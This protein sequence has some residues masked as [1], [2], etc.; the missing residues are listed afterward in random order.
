MPKRKKLPPIPDYEVIGSHSEKSYIQKARPLQSLSATNLTLPELKILDAYLARI[1]SHN[2]DARYVRFDKGELER[3]LGVTQL[4]K[5]DLS[6]RIDNLF[7]VI[8]ITDEHKPTKFSKIALFS[9]AECEQDENGQWQ[10]D[11]ACSV[12]AMEYMFNIDNIGYL[13]YRLKNVINLT[14]RYSYILFLYLVDNRFRKTWKIDL[15]D[16]KKLMNCTAE[17]YTE[18]KFF[19]SEI[20]KKCQNEIN[21][22]TDLKFDYKPVR[23]GRKVSSIEFTVETLNEQIEEQFYSDN[24]SAPI[25]LIE[26]D[27][28]E[29]KKSDADISSTELSSSDCDD[30]LLYY[31]E[32]LDNQFTKEEL[33]ELVALVNK[34]YPDYNDKQKYGCLNYSW[35]KL[36]RYDEKKK[37]KNKISYLM[38]MITNDF[39]ETHQKSI[40]QDEKKKRAEEVAKKYEIFTKV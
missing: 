29:N 9:K 22:K 20:I 10:I 15:S 3:L 19:N 39:N 36:L 30:K 37:I 24:I 28:K 33:K 11:L 27:E 40:K 6:K 4:K 14:S 16:L 25:N 7:Q 2:P 32:A 8:T 35:Y 26:C 5:E 38:T 12:E 34:L 13:R 21:E 1:N 18:F 17:R 23:K 31:S